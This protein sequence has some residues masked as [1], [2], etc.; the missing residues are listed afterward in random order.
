MAHLLFA[1]KNTINKINRR[2]CCNHK[3]THTVQRTY[4]ILN[5]TA[6]IDIQ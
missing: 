1:H 6:I 3:H 5:V 4:N 2:H